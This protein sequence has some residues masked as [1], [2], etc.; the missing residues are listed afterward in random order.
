M[1]YT[2]LK[3]ASK[4]EAQFFIEDR[5]SP[6]Y[7]GSSSNMNYVWQFHIARNIYQCLLHTKYKWRHEKNTFQVFE[8]YILFSPPAFQEKKSH[9]LLFFVF[10]FNWVALL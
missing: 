3:E 5:Q 2:D 6:E 9:N 10:D 1:Y 7:P 8:D 4:E